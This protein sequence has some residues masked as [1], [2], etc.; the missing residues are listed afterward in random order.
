MLSL[1]HPG[2]PGWGGWQAIKGNGGLD[3]EQARNCGAR[4]RSCSDGAT[5]WPNNWGQSR[6]PRSWHHSLVRVSPCGHGATTLTS[7]I[8]LPS[9][10]LDT[11]AAAVTR[12]CQR[13]FPGVT[14]AASRHAMTVNG[15]GLMWPQLSANSPDRSR[16]SAA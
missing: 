15:T 10:G 16:T 11:H 2:L 4:V 1:V 12:R 3:H 6:Q 9:H 7:Q 14:E 13:T 5:Y 8:R